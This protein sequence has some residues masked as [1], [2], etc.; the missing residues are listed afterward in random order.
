MHHMAVVILCHFASV[1]KVFL[2]GTIVKFD[3]TNEYDFQILSR[4]GAG[5]MR[6]VYPIFEGFQPPPLNE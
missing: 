6:L 4:V 1:F 5:A 3:G 2:V